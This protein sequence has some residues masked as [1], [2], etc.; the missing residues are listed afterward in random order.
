MMALFINLSD[1]LQNLIFK[2]KA[3]NIPIERFKQQKMKNY[4][5]DAKKALYGVNFL[6]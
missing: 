2:L 4:T 1:N 3:K 5:S 6:L